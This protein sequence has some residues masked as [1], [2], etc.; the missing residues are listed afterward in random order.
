ME[1]TVLKVNNQFRYKIILKCRNS[2]RFREMMSGLLREFGTSKAAAG[3]RYYA[4]MGFDGM[5]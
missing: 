1:S 3:I 4:D 5:V 2:K